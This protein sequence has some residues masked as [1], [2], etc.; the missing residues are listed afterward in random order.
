MAE[1]IKV[2]QMVRFMNPD[3]NTMDVGTLMGF[4]GGDLKVQTREGIVYVAPSAVRG[5][6]RTRKNKRKNH[7]KSRRR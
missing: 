1:Q 3:T 2:G 6:K 5:G 7:R 4:E